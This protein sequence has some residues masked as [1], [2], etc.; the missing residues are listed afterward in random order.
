MSRREEDQHETEMH[1]TKMPEE[2][3]Q[4]DEPVRMYSL[5][6][7]D[8]LTD[9]VRR[10]ED[11]KAIDTA[12]TDGST[13][14]PHQAQEQGL[15][16]DPPSDPPVIPSDDLQGAEIATGFASSME[17]ANADVRDLPP[18]VDN[19]DLDLEE[20]IRVAL[21]N[22]SE[23]THLSDVDVTVRNGVAYLRGTVFS[24]DDIAIVHYIVRDLEGVR[25]V[26]NELEVD[27]G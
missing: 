16:Y 11:L 24:D 10:E 4:E 2:E 19:Q 6:E 5:E 27:V 26:R 3:M 12:H 7:L 17:E 20:D 8:E 21:R 14:N 15:V 18:R 1:E 13:T 25:D 22:N 9:E 23:T